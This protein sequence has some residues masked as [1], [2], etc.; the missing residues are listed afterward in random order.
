MHSLIDVW[1]G[2]NIYLDYAQCNSLP[3]II[4]QS[5][6]L[7]QSKLTDPSLNSIHHNTSVYETMGTIR[8]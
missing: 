5:R 4:G 8:W 2:K 7:M 6:L 3:D 1:I